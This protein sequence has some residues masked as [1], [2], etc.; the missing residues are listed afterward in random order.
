[1]TRI[2]VVDDE[3]AIRDSVT[4][5]LEREGFDVLAAADGETA[6]RVALEERFD[7]VVL[8]IMLP[9]I[10]GTEVCRRLRA[11]SAVPI[12]MLTAR[13]GEIDR[14]VGLEIGADDYVAKP[15]SMPELVARI[16]AL[17]RRRELDRDEEGA[18]RRVGAIE[19]D[20][21]RHEVRVDGVRVDLTP[22]EFKLLALL[23]SDPGRAWPRRDLIR[24]LW[25]SDH[26]GDERAVDAHVVNLRRKLEAD[27][28]DPKRL[29]TVRGVGYSLL[30]V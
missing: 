2:L 14:V 17:L 15:F 11:E 20:F 1:M 27:A 29:V 9:A 30:A 4:Y 23:A 22:A 16:R 5:A 8:D 6:L 13:T 25:D 26:G 10:S 28:A 3:P 21:R 24:H 7:A 18:Y 19:L 12:L